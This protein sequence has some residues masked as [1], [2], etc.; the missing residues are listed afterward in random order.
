MKRYYIQIKQQSMRVLDALMKNLS[1]SE[2]HA[3]RL[4][5]Q[6]SVW[7]VQPEKRVKDGA[8]VVQDLLLR[9]NIPLYP[10]KECILQPDAIVYED[11]WLAVVYKQANVPVHPTPYSDIDS[12]AWAIGNHYG[13]S[14]GGYVPSVINRLDK[15]TQGLVFFA[16]DKETE[17]RLHAMFREHMMKKRYIAT[18]LPFSGVEQSYCIRDNVEWNGKIK[19]ALTYVRCVGKYNGLLY[20]IV[21]PQTGRTH[22]IRQH[23]KKRI[24][25]LYGDKK[26]GSGSSFD[27]MGLIC[28]EYK[29]KHPRTGKVIRIRKIPEELQTVLFSTM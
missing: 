13:D 22:Q 12:L 10:V 3:S 17:R 23:F 28:F 15:P 16:K 8:Q 29:F 4:L 18:T 20:F 2:E 5:Y 25:P 14:L 21:F 6:G 11:K 19:D 9:V 27:E 24:A 26:Y 1:L 7:Q